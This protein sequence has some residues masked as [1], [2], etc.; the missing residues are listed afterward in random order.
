MLLTDHE[1][2]ALLGVSRATVWNWTR[3]NDG[4]PQPRRLSRGATRWMR[5]EIIAWINARK[6]AAE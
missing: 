2:A 1:V 3:G 5:A 6:E 4:F